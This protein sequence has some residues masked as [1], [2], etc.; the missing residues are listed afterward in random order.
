MATT[1]RFAGSCV[2]VVLCG[3]RSRRMGRDK[4][5]LPIDGVPMGRRV[6]DALRAASLD[7]VVAVGGDPSLAGLLD[8]EHLADRWP[9]EGPLGGIL[10]ALGEV[11]AD[12]TV[13]V[14]PCDLVAPSAEAVRHVLSARDRTDADLAV[15]VVEGRRQW[16]HAAWH[17]RVAAIVGDV[18]ASGE[19]SI[20]GATL[21]LRT[22]LVDD[23]PTVAV[24]D[25]DRPGE[26]PAGARE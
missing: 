3:G 23:L 13:V 1:G 4:A 2:G 22:V 12:A 24:R 14:L 6:A 25:A 11:G 19:R 26:L 8:V 5:T 10:T 16:L 9:G 7:R 21:G 18:F 15:P 17:G 20:A